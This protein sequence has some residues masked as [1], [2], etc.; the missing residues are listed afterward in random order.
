MQQIIRLEKGKGYVSDTFMYKGELALCEKTLRKYFAM[1]VDTKVIDLVISDKKTKNS[2]KVKYN[3]YKDI[4]R[5]LDIETKGIRKQ[6]DTYWGLSRI[7]PEELH[8]KVVYVS[9]EV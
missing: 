9:I 3:L 6:E 8:N 4:V 2:Y 5:F 7:L 1:P